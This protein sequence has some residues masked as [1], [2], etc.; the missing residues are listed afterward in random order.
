MPY[1]LFL[2]DVR[3]PM[4]IGDIRTWII[5]RSYKEFVKA[6][7]ERGLPDLISFDHDLAIEHYPQSSIDMEQSIDYAK[8][9]E[10][11]GYHCA[12]WLVEYCKERNL[13]LPECRIH[14]MNP[15]GR[16]NIFQVL[17]TYEKTYQP[18]RNY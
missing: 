2:D 5:V 11:T 16:I 17:D 12:Q 9:K 7:T 6:I 4:N 13:P 15:V 18:I 10:K 1:N 8:Y 3:T 14:S